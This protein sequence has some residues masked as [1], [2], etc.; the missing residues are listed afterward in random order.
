M[1]P[2][3]V[4]ALMLGLAGCAGPAAATGAGANP[5]L[6]AAERLIDAFY[7]FDPR[8]LREALAHAPESQP[9]IL[10]Y[11]G[12]AQ[13]GNYAVLVRKPCASVSPGELTCA[14]TVRDDL[15]VALGTGYWVT[16]TFHLTVED[17][18]IVKVRTSSNDPADF[19]LAL[20]WLQREQPQVMTGPCRGFFAGGPTPQDCVRAVVKG[21]KAYRD[22]KPAKLPQVGRPEG[23]GQQGREL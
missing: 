21:F 5:P 3:M 18:R 17:G 23:V 11:Q 19:E 20:N 10:F 22:S 2:I 9:Q 8:R 13:G 4:I 14:I 1:R 6:A 12:W 16:D 15:I 7:S